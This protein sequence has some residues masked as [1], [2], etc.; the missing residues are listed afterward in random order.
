M[1]GA[2]GRA[3]MLLGFATQPLNFVGKRFR[4]YGDMYFVTHAPGLLVLRHPDH[5]YEVLVEKAADFSKQHTAFEQ[6]GRVLGNGLLNSDGDVWRRHRRMIQPA[7]QRARLVEYAAEMRAEAERLADELAPPRSVE[8]SD[9]MMGLTLDIVC[10]TLFSHDSSAD[11]DDVNRAMSAFQDSIARPDVLPSWMPSPSRKALHNAV[12][13]LDAIMF[14]MIRERKSE[15]ATG[16]EPRTDLLARLLA[17]VDEEGDGQGLTETEV[18]DQLV[19]L[20][21]AG[22]ET[23]SQALT[24]TWFLLAQ[25]PEVE[26]ALHQELSREL[27]GRAP[28]YEDLQRLTFTEQVLE[29]SMRLYPPV[30]MV[31]RRAER[32]TTVG[33][34]QVSA[35]TELALWIY[36]AHRDPRWFALPDAFRPERFAPQ[37]KAKIRRGAYVPFGAGPRACI[38]KVFAMIEAKIILATLAQRF[39]ARVAPGQKVQALPRITLTPRHG[40]RML[41]Q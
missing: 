5:L 2:L 34:V 23:T 17:A 25:H 31:A 8:M 3:Q 7:F 41:L 37:A 14:R 10:R 40:M 15:I 6:L 38:G 26:S 1:P 18:R 21:L 20:F 36:W 30:Y 13:T 19:T 29:E 33:D 27:G 24:W 16:A 4:R 32:D 11:R 39:R 22:H 35:G 12:G 28:D 9:A